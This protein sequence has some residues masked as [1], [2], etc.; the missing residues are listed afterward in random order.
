MA[1]WL[2]LEFLTFFHLIFSLP[3]CNPPVVDTEGKGRHPER[4]PL[5][6]FRIY[7]HNKSC[8]RCSPLLNRSP[9]PH[10][11]GVSPGKKDRAQRPASRRR[12]DCRGPESRSH[13]QGFLPRERKRPN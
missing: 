6:I 9:L 11:H 4:L 3:A 13:N 7:A 5:L 2:C 10:H 12:K 1:D 8:S